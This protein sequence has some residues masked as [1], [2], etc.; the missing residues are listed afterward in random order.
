MKLRRSLVM[1]AVIAAFLCAPAA[2]AQ[3]FRGKIQGLVT[4]STEAAIAGATVTLANVNTGV[5]TIRQ[6]N[7]IGRYIFDYVNPGSYAITVESAGFGKFIQENIQV[8]TLADITVNATLR[9]GALQESIVVKESPVEVQ[10]N[11]SHNSMTINTEL[12]NKL[13]RFDRNPFKLALLNPAVVNT[14]GEVLPYH[15]WAANSIELGGG[16]N[17]KND[18]QVD[19]SPIGLGHKATYTPN[20]DAVQ[21]VIVAQNSV[22]AESG[23][24]GGGI[25]SMTLKSGTNQWHGSAFFL[26]RNPALN[27]LADRTTRVKTA[28]RNNM[29]GGTLGNPIRKNKV[30]NFFSWEQWRPREPVNYI[31]TV[32]TP[33]ER[34]GDFSQSLN[35]DRGV[36]TIF[37]PT[38]TVF[39]A[40]NNKATRQPF[41]GNVIPQNRIDPLAAQIMKQFW[42]PNN[43]GDNITGVNNYKAAPIRTI[44]YYNYSNRTDVDLSSN[45]R[46]FGRVSRLHTMVD[47]ANPT[48]N[49]SQIFVP[50][51]ASARHAFSV[52]GDAVWTVNPRTVLNFHGDYH[53]LVDDYASPP[54]D[55]GKAGLD[56]LWPNN[57]WYA[58]Y[59]SGLAEYFPRFSAGS[60][61]GRPGTFWNQHPNGNDFNVKISQQRGAHYLKAGFDTQHKGGFTLV[62]GVTTFNFPVALT[63]ETFLSPDT[64]HLGSPLATLLLGTLDSGT[65]AI[66][67]PV[68]NPRT[69]FYGLFF[70]DDYKLNRRITLNL[71]LRYEY[72]TA[73]SDPERRMSRY[74]DLTQPIPEMQAN[75]PQIPQQASSIMNVPYK[76]NGAWVFTDNS[77]PGMWDPPKAVFMPRAGIAV[78]VSDRTS[79]RVGWAR[80]T[81]PSEFN[82]TTENP[83]PGFEAINFLEA[84]YPGFDVT[85]SASPLL[86][87]KP[88]VRW[89]DPFP[90]GLNP[91]IPPKGKG[92]GRYLGLGG[93]NLIW[94]HPDFKRGVNDRLNVTFSHQLP[95]Y[96]VLDITYFANFGH[97]LPYIQYLDLADPNLSYTYKGAVDVQV[98]NPFYQYL[99]P[100]K[101][102]GPLRNQRTVTV[103][104]LLKPYPQ[105]AGLFE[106]F[107]PGKSERYHSLEIRAQRG[108]RGGYNFLFG[109]VYQR[110]KIYEWYDDIARYQGK[111]AYQNTTEPHQRLSAGG[112]YEFP[113]G[114]GR[115]FL[116]QPHPVLQGILGGWQT[117][118]AWYFNTG[119]NLRFGSMLA[120]GNPT[121]SNPTPQRWFDTT[122][123]QRLPAFT[124]RSN[125]WQYDGLF[126]PR[127][128][129][130][131]LSLMKYFQVTE[132]V[133]TEFKMSAY[134]AT[135]RLN[136]ADP[137]LGVTSSTFGQTLRQSGSTGR[138]VEFG[139]KIIF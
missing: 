92:Y 15:S 40:A 131:D 122:K 98:N 26:S 124:P 54:N 47:T 22:D 132:R 128:W 13:P 111:F 100:D 81:I 119:N 5:K 84:P 66:S 17:L 49:R 110:Q 2:F 62:T 109:Y 136:R 33:L 93:D 55:I 106:A 46:V 3:E 58:P 12:A 133:K 65:T 139:L 82:F 51:D 63:A 121:I 127:F 72:E 45:W 134:N 125:P 14:R 57:P 74:N 114:K 8:Q 39:D 35:I 79:V 90:T 44:G 16:T 86:E 70:Q 50:G 95:N 28:A 126:G 101:F 34:A 43:P 53:S 73:W 104:S 42:D 27:A 4:D 137:D 112:A 24:S 9:P 129:Q 6:T 10:F 138:Q 30:F 78:R 96:I 80:Y 130:M 83:F 113:F 87:G 67:K 85:Q 60:T 99:T 21:E 123:F 11:S 116:T 118:G 89:S 36:R 59:L 31:A 117:I 29:W 19:G 32:P 64:L 20:T 77:H 107:S 120:S 7:E 71:G 105:Y 94:M 88:Q 38:T 56:K 37:D 135:N 25:I 76:W 52:S 103:G 97:D 91:L 48:P 18:L 69:G 68:K 23:H 108:F 115:K 61:F 102:P 75:P 41:A 1:A